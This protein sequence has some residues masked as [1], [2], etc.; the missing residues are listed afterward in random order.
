MNLPNVLVFLFF[1]FLFLLPVRLWCHLLLCS[2]LLL[3]SLL[4]FS[5]PPLFSPVVS[6]IVHLS[7][8]FFH[9]ILFTNFSFLSLAD[10][11]RG[12]RGTA[13]EDLERLHS[14]LKAQKSQ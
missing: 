11:K 8:F 7:C 5:F 13:V 6:P 1:F 14:E 3:D 12:R 10:E 4:A 9:L 2:Q